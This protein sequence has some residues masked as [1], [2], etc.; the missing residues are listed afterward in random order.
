MT[1]LT[2]LPYLDIKPT[3]CLNSD[4]CEA[5]SR[6]RKGKGNKFNGHQNPS[7]ITIGKIDCVAAHQEYSE[8]GLP[9]GI[10]L[11][12]ENNGRKF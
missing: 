8:L 9:L 12:R 5:K 4:V 3:E 2:L 10:D 7:K 6:K 11:E 1:E